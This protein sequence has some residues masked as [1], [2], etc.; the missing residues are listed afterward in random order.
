MC[1]SGDPETITSLHRAIQMFE[2]IWDWC[3]SVVFAEQITLSTLSQVA[4][5]FFL[6]YSKFDL[7]VFILIPVLIADK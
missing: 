6:L 5:S 3:I 2:H 1:Y 7:N 4:F